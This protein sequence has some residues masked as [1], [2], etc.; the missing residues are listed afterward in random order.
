MTSG[1]RESRTCL[2][3]YQAT[4]TISSS[5]AGLPKIQS[6]MPGS[7]RLYAEMLILWLPI[8]LSRGWAKR[9]T[10]ERWRTAQAILAVRYSSLM[11]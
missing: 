11:C 7:G 6:A 1:K 2:G 9:K 10:A 4:Q 3:G 8:Q 5:F